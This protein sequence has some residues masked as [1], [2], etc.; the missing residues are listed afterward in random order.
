M[1]ADTALLPICLPTELNFFE[2]VQFKFTM[3]WMG[4]QVS[5]GSQ[6]HPLWTLQGST[7]LSGD[8]GFRSC[9][10]QG[11]GAKPERNPEPVETRLQLKVGEAEKLGGLAE[12]DLF[13]QVGSQGSDIRILRLLR[14]LDR[15]LGERVEEPEIQ[16]IQEH[17]LL[18]PGTFDDH[19]LSVPDTIDDF[20]G[21]LG[22][23]G[24][25]DDR[26][27]HRSPRCR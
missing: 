26:A 22:K 19:Y 20:L 12:T 7:E 23:A 8:G 15:T 25:R 4:A 21:M 11:G 18:L 2:P 3:P 13:G 9:F 24:L 17:G 16:G 10:F 6:V 27:S 14:L 5:I 1:P